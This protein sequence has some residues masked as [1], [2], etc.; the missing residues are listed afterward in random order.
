MSGQQ[1]RLTLRRN[2]DGSVSQPMDLKWADVLSKLTD[3]EDLEEAGLL[4]RIP[5]KPG[6]TVMAYLSSPSLDLVECVITGIEHNTIYQEPLFTAVSYE[7]AECNTFW[8]SDFGKE[9]FTMD[10]YYTMLDEHA[11]RRKKREE[12]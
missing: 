4:W 1:K 7:K 9:I 12:G 5:V 10:Q 11:T 6:D 3:Y 8:L 2:S